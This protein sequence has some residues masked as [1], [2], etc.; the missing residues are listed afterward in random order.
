MLRRLLPVLLVLAPLPLAAQAPDSSTITLERVFESPFFS[1]QFA[2]PTRW[3]P[4]GE[5]YFSSDRR[6]GTKGPDLVRVNPETGEK[7][8]LVRSEQLVPAGDSV[9]LR[10]ASYRFS[11]DGRKVLL[12]TNTARVW[13]LNTRGDYWVLDLDSG[14]LRKLGGEAAKPQTLMFAKFAPQGDRVAYV[15]ENNLYVERV[16]DGRIIPLTRD[17]S[18]TLINGTFDWV[19]EEEFSARDGFRWSP[20]GQ[21]IAYWQLDASGVRDFLLLNTTDSLY[22]F[23]VPV[24]Y[25]KAGST[26]S[27][28]RI[29]VVPAAGGPTRWIQVPGSPRDIYVARMEWAGTSDEIAFQHLNRLQN[30]LTVFLAD[31]KT[32]RSRPV[33][34]DR[35]SAWVDVVD[36]WDWLDGG[37]RF[38]WISERDG[39]RHAW[40]ISRDGTRQTLLTPGAFDIADVVQVDVKG[41]WIYYTASPENPTQR[42]LYRSPLDG[43][44]TQERL[45][46][47]GQFGTHGYNLA[48]GAK[49]AI[50]TFSNIDTPPRT[51]LVR[52]PGHA[53]I[54]TLADNAELRHRMGLL[55][56]GPARFTRVDAG[57]GVWL[58]ALVMYPA[59]FDSTKQYPVLFMV[60]GEPAAQTAVDRWNAMDPWHLML[61]QMG[62]AVITMDNRGTP[63][64]RGRDWRKAIYRKIGVYASE[65]QAGAARAIGRWPWVDSTRLGVWGWSGGGS[66]TLNLLFRFPEVYR[67]GMSVAPVP[68][69]HLYD[70]IYQERYMGL[71]GPN[72]EDYRLSSPVTF[73]DRLRGNLLVVHGTGDDNVH[74]QGT[75]R[76]INALVAANKQFK[77]LSYPNRTHGIFEGEGTTLHLFSRLT[78]YLVKYLPAGGR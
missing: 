18:R 64:L 16:R 29:G 30:T 61:T 49:Y 74:Y 31:R 73:A 3:T 2:P 20:D 62:Y 60:Y 67:T 59:D 24:Q 75:E 37:A 45:S 4:D 70:T 44:G 55:R 65:D 52:L 7:T 35:D 63:S 22:S 40:T 48:P 54:R 28:V 76:L 69:V 1:G 78:E 47:M 56:R 21:A 68:D 51:E 19:Y 32:G 36:D 38:V 39:W 77:L 43:R 41:G 11:D 9:P 58:D 13:R 14:Q 50:H 57:N 25:P 17:G 6:P 26:N 53:L 71:P 10:A 23:T 27:A 66:M 46:P 33:F 15:R 34:T 72:A 8:V 5:A 42:Y 12:F